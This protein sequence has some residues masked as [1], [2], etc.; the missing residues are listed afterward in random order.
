MSNDVRERM[1][2]LL[3]D[4]EVYL[5]TEPP[6][7]DWAWSL[8]RETID[9]RK[10]FRSVADAT[11]SHEFIVKHIGY[12]LVAWG[13][14]G[15]AA[16]LAP[17]EDFFTSIREH[18][19][20][21]VELELFSVSDLTSRQLDDYIW[22]LIQGLGLSKGRSQV[23]TGSKVLHHLFPK[24]MPPID[25]QYTA[26]FFTPGWLKNTRNPNS[27]S[28]FMVIANGFGLIA[29]VL[30]KHNGEDYLR[31]LVGSTQWA[32]SETKLIDNAIIGYVKKHGL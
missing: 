7:G 3:A 17:R 13:M 15:R 1:A 26:K 22:K 20:H 10:Q 16:E 21:L 30:E 14:D 19:R 29:T 18:R 5:E 28:Q 32:T 25:H 31:N 11:E 23:V 9:M 8:H 24:L 6:F 4:F 2:D 12:T 27:K